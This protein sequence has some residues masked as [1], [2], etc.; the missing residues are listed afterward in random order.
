MKKTL[1]LVILTI[2]NSVFATTSSWTTLT[3]P[4]LAPCTLKGINSNKI[5]CTY[6]RDPD[7]QK[8]HSAVYY[9]ST[10]K[11][12][13]ID[14]PSVGSLGTDMRDI[15][16]NNV[17]G[18]YFDTDWRGCIYNLETGSWTTINIPISGST[19][20][21]GIDGDNV[22]GYYYYENNWHGF[23]YNVKT[24]VYTTIDKPGAQ[25][26][27]PH[28]ISGQNIVG[29]YLD[30]T[31]FHGFIY[32]VNTHVWTT[33]DVPTSTQTIVTGIDGDNV[34]GY[35]NAAFSFIYNINTQTWGT[36]YTDKKSNNIF[37][38]NIGDNK[39][40]FNIDGNCLIYTISGSFNFPIC[41]APITGDLDENCKVDYKDFAIM[42][43]H[44]LD[45]NMLPSSACW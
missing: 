15:D 38:L 43:S 27:Y 32:N 29:D 3:I 24:A 23:I 40:L 14:K 44:W 22:I 31:A 9:M 10:A 34:V 30:G 18:S 37:P 21:Y 33:I 19:Q 5:V 35:Y 39:I 11:W 12:I 26:T 17:V 45:C 28:G 16:G 8:Y 41:L 2:V 42:A 6:S 36:I 4:G 13:N 1:V 20:P 7:W 25:Q